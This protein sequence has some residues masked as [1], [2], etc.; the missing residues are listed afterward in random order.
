MLQLLGEYECRVDAKGR[1]RL[2]SSLLAQ[3]GID[4]DSERAFVLNRGFDNCLMLYTEE[5]WKEEAKVVDSL[6]PYD[7]KN[8]KFIRSF[9][10][11]AQRLTLDSAGRILINN[12]LKE[13]AGIDKD[14]ILS[15]V[16]NSIEIWAKDR[17]DSQLDE[18]PE[19]L[20]G[21][22]QQVLGNKKPDQG[23]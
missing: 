17:Y 6:N 15:A 22:A 5:V 20:S 12:R 7:P 23:E 16:K 8:R 1:M 9:Y 2:P 10:R 13:H 11:G 14:V 3:L 18:E 19:D 4:E 21:L